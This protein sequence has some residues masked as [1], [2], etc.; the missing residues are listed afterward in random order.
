M[1][2]IIFLLYFK[3]ESKCFV[4]ISQR[5]EKKIKVSTINIWKSDFPWLL[6]KNE[7]LFCEICVSQKSVIEL[8]ITIHPLQMVVRD[9]NG[10]C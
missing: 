3:D 2:C 9:F 6:V 5:K 4:S 8:E 1:L 10:V 7:T